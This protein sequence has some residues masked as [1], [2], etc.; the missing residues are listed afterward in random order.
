MT[1]MKKK[2]NDISRVASG[3]MVV[4]VVA[5]VIIGWVAAVVTSGEAGISK[6][7]PWWRE[8]SAIFFLMA[9]LWTAHFFLPRRIPLTASV[10]L[11]AVSAM[12]TGFSVAFFRPFGWGDLLW[13]VSAL[14]ASIAILKLLEPSGRTQ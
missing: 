1:D 13:P 12:I 9:L 2:D 7:E 11:A 4:A 6:L 3:L 8:L 14:F 10:I 5:L